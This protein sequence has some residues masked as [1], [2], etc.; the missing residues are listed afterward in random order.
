M[1]DERHKQME[2]SLRRVPEGDDALID[3]VL[4]ILAALYCRGRHPEEESGKKNIGKDGGE[5]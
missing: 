5:P 4:R 1:A 2:E 3:G